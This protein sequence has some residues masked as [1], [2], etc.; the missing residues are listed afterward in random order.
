MTDRQALMPLTVRWSPPPAAGKTL[1]LVFAYHGRDRDQATPSRL[2][3]L[4]G[5][6][7]H[8]HR[9]VHRDHYANPRTLGYQLAMV[10]SAAELLTPDAA[11]TFVFDTALGDEVPRAGER[12]D[13]AR[14]RYWHD[15]IASRARE[16][17]NVVAVYPDALG[18][19][20]QDAEHRL[21]RECGSI[22][23]INGRR[24]AFRVDHAMS[25]RMDVH[26]WLADTRA[27]E[28]LLARAMRPYAAALAL[29][30]RM[31]RGAV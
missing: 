9:I 3:R 20:C 7:A 18:L 19:G 23:V 27:F 17:Q 29:W 21:V 15:S 8:G 31:A 16:F 24:R 6:G 10:R 22:L 25:R 5:P 4:E 28:R 13:L 2:E 30:D 1:F 14:P 11:P 26:R 12:L